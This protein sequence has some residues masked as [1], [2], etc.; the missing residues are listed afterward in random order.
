MISSTKFL[1]GRLPLASPS[2]LL[3]PARSGSVPEEGT[4]RSLAHSAAVRPSPEPPPPVGWVIL[5]SVISGESFSVSSSPCRLDRFLPDP[6][7]RFFALLIWIGWMFSSG[8]FD[9]LFWNLLGRRR[10]PG[11]FRSPT[12]IR[13]A[14][15]PRRPDS[16]LQRKMHF[17]LAGP[18]LDASKC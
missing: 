18:R 16:L 6:P 11:G 10:Q 17:F 7:T 4:T 2:L 5:R 1:G 8:S 3:C 15:A 14:S 12:D 13:L 9:L